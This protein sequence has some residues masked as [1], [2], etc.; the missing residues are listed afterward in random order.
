MN[1][2]AL[3]SPAEIAANVQRPRRSLGRI[4]KCGGD[5]PRA[6]TSSARGAVVLVR[7]QQGDDGVVTV[8]SGKEGKA[9][10]VVPVQV[11]EQDRAGERPAAS[12]GVTWRSPVPASRMS[13]GGAAGSWAT[14]THEVWPPYRTKSAP[15]AGVDP[16]TPQKCSR[17]D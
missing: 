3:R 17:T 4:G 10:R 9:L 16:R 12:S 13:V 8:C 6:S 2:S 5:I 1:P 14:A 15:G 11:G 7:Q